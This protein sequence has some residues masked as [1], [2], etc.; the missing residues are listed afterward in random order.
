MLTVLL[1]L[2]YAKDKNPADNVSKTLLHLAAFN[3]HLEIQ[4]TMMARLPF[5]L[6]NF[7]F[8]ESNDI[9]YNILSFLPASE[10]LRAYFLLCCS[11]S[12][13]CC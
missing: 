11:S 10:A 5:T 12:C 4:Q 13:C 7:E 8:F 1:I 2:Q 9:G 3:G 6:Q